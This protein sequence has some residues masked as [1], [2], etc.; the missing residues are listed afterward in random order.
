MSGD[1]KQ[2]LIGVLYLVPFIL[3]ILAGAPYMN[4]AIG[5][6]QA[7]LCYELARLLTK[8]TTYIA[9]YS[10]Y[11]LMT[12]LGFS[13]DLPFIILAVM[14]LGCFAMGYMAKGLFAAIFT[15]ILVICLIS[16]S[17]LLL[18]EEAP[19]I[20]LSLALIIGAGDIGAYLV[21]RRLGGRKLAPLISPKKTVSGALGGL[22]ASMI[23]GLAVAPHIAPLNP[24]PLIAA[25]IIGVIGQIGD[26]YESYFKRKLDVKDSS[27]L[28][29]GHGGF[30]DRFDGYLF[31][32]PVFL[33]SLI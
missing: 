15:S 1:L 29:P 19:L 26:L 6:L 7:L 20:L 24:N 13:F 16:L 2:R 4:I 23:V 17:L 22:V 25:M 18:F 21:G 5:I 28:I 14:A 30:L 27:D 32:I 8:N 11:F 3:A 10:I 33:F 12:V 31:V 9:L